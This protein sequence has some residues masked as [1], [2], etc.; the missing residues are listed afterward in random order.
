[1]FF[2]MAGGAAASNDLAFCWERSNETRWR[3]ERYRNHPRSSA[4]TPG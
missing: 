3:G 2:G 1:M 4:E